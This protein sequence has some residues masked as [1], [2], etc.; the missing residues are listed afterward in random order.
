VRDLVGRLLDS[1]IE[2]RSQAGIAA[3]EG[4]AL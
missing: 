1:E 3:P 2:G 4:E